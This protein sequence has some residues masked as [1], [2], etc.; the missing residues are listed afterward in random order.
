MKIESRVESDHEPQEIKI[1]AKQTEGEE[2]QEKEQLIVDWSEEATKKYREKIKEK[3]RR[4]RDE[5]MEKLK[6]LIRGK[7]R[8]RRK[9]G[10]R[11]ETDCG[12]KNVQREEKTLKKRRKHLEVEKYMVRK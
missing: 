3:L 5:N 1:R 2:E 12:I 6:E 7:T 8:L 10:R 4:K 11:H 9:K